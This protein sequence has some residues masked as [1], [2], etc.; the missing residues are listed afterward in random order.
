LPSINSEQDENIILPIPD[1]ISAC[2]N[3]SILVKEIKEEN[4]NIEIKNHF[5]KRIRN[6]SRRWLEWKEYIDRSN[7]LNIENI[8]DNEI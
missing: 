6:H 5:E 7:E 4:E 2:L 1:E 8:Y 3:E